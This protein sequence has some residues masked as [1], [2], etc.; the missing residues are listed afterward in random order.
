MASGISGLLPEDLFY[1]LQTSNVETAMDIH[2][3]RDALI[4]V[5]QQLD[6]QPGGALA[7]AGGDAIVDAINRFAANFTE[8]VITQD[9]HPKGHVSF[10]SSYCDRSP[11]SRIT[12]EQVERGEIELSGSAAFTLEELRVY[13]QLARGNEQALWPDHCVIGTNGEALDPRLDLARATL[14]LRKGYRPAAD[15]YSAF[16][17]NDGT[18]T[19]LA[20]CLMVKEIERVFVVGLAGDY[21]V[22][23]T[24]IDGAES[25][26]EAV[27]LE[28]L[29]RFVDASADS[30][31]T[32]YTELRRGGVGVE[33]S[34]MPLHV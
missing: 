18:S 21:C 31:E 34:G 3:D 7:V 14:I 1:L 20:E 5:D 16:R 19:G 17:E 15:S 28:D 10:A 12:L 32:A 9:H 27:Y 33:I 23:Y 26:L 4:I 13:L 6:F 25:G 22:L 29:T 11:Y 2:P 8:V 30:K 24:A